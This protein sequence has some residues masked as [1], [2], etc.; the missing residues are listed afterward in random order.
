[1]LA[2][3]LE[4][5]VQRFGAGVTRDDLAVLVVRCKVPRVRGASAVTVEA[6]ALA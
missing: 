4:Q 2:G 6:V 1:M 5:Q 3:Q